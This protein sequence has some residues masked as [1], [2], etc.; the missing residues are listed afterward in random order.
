MHIHD[1]CCANKQMSFWSKLS[2]HPNVPLRYSPEINLPITLQKATLKYRDAKKMTLSTTE[3]MKPIKGSDPYQT[4]L[5]PTKSKWRIKSK[6]FKVNF[7][8]LWPKI[9][10]SSKRISLMLR[11]S[12]Y[13][14][15]F[16]TDLFSMWFL[17][18][19]KFSLTTVRRKSKQNE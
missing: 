15:Y 10:K 4:Q 7:T 8:C 12:E 11:R 16:T 1:S 9:Q 3:W 13:S 17:T 6:N 19:N 18:S 5:K 2:R 14:K